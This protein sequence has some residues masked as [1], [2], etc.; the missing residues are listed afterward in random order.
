MS[1]QWYE[2]S[3]QF[4][5]EELNA[6]A[7][8]EVALLADG[9]LFW[10]EVSLEYPLILGKSSLA[11][12]FRPHPTI[13]KSALRHTLFF[14]LGWRVGRIGPWDPA[15]RNHK[16]S[17]LT[18]SIRPLP[19]SFIHSSN[20]QWVPVALG[21]RDTETRPGTSHQIQET[22]KQLIRLPCRL[23]GWCLLNHS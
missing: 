19:H 21:A 15:E 23:L 16:P 12:E 6:G 9:H 3:R 18:W 17:Q 20:K 7:G 13:L 22:K 4:L 5:K 14:C 11:K 2:S 1:C 8:R 10:V